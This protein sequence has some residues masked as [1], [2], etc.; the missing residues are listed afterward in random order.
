[1]RIATART[2]FLSLTIAVLTLGMESAAADDFDD[3]NSG[4]A[5]RMISGCTH[6][7]ETGQIDGTPISKRNLAAAYNNRG[8][9]HFDN[10]EYSLAIADHTEAIRLDP[11]NSEAYGSR[12]N[13]YA[14]Y[15]EYE[16]A[17]QDLTESVHLAPQQSVA[18]FNRGLAHLLYENYVDAVLD[19]KRAVILEPR[20]P[21]MR[22]SLGDT[23]YFTGDVAGAVEEWTEACALASPT[24]AQR[25]QY[26]LAELGHYNGQ[27]DGACTVQTI[28]AFESCARDGC[29]F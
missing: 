14:Y 3:C 8:T 17:I 22:Q 23:Y 29:Y 26:R 10:R 7:I 24:L 1:M 6:L 5:S 12:G 4:L 11:L 18:Y 13:A 2:V 9:A 28:N 20:N 16:L 27:V 19:F 15:G 21:T 25:W